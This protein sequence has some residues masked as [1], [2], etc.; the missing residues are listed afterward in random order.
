MVNEWRSAQW[1]QSETPMHSATRL[2]KELNY[3]LMQQ[4]RMVSNVLSIDG[5]SVLR[6]APKVARNGR[7]TQI[8]DKLNLQKRRDP[9][10][11]SGDRKVSF[12]ALAFVDLA[13]GTKFLL[14]YLPSTSPE[15]YDIAPSGQEHISWNSEIQM[16]LTWRQDWEGLWDNNAYV[17]Q[18]LLVLEDLCNLLRRMWICSKETR[19]PV[20]KC[21]INH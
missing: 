7:K 9:R 10:P 21:I 11:I 14:W 15:V 17:R 8:Q 2:W 4:R 16:F 13:W 3:H 12:Q 20:W 1:Q 18:M 5:R 19:F 6:R